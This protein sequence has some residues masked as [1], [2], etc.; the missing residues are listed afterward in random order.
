MKKHNVFG[1]AVAV[2]PSCWFY[3]CPK[4]GPLGS[5]K[6]QGIGYHRR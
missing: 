6:Y 1:I 3:R 4:H 2:T 5:K